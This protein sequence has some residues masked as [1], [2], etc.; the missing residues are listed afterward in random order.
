M[1]HNTPAERLCVTNTPLQSRLAKYKHTVCDCEDFVKFC[2]NFYFVAPARGSR[3]SKKRLR[4][5]E[6]CVKQ[7]RIKVLCVRRNL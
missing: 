5:V 7:V 6:M 4:A 1:A 3:A 2:L